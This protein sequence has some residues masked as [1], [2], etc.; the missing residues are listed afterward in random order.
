[1]SID[2]NKSLSKIEKFR[3]LKS[4]LTGQAY[5]VVEDF[6]LAVRCK[7]RSFHQL[8]E[9]FGK[10]DITIN[11]HMNNLLII[12]PVNVSSN[13]KALGKFLDI[14]EINIRI[15]SNLNV[16]SGSYGHL[17]HPIL[18]KLYCHKI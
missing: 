13:L 17:L 16:T 9:R 6:T 11:A 12:E 1:M 14:Y 3:Y 7:Y 15:L 4:F 18:L 10:L 5:N 8:K 2:Q